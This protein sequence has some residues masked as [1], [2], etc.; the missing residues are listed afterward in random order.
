MSNKVLTDPA[1]P[2]VDKLITF[3]YY[4]DMPRIIKFYEEV[5]GFKLVIDQEWSKIYQISD[6]GYVGLVDETRGYHRASPT[7]PVMI[8]MRVPDVYVWYRHLKAKG[9][10][11][12][13][14]PHDSP[15]LKIRAFMLQDPEGYVIEIQEA[16]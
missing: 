12:L 2:G 5:M 14:E 9:V 16:L 13:S 8:C 3:L 6:S 1:N 7:K 4:K 11:M 15:E 10:Q